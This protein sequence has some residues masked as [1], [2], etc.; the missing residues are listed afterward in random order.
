VASDDGF[1]GIY[2]YLNNF[3]RKSLEHITLEGKKEEKATS[4][5]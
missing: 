1:V 5:T 4:Q 2:D 3:D